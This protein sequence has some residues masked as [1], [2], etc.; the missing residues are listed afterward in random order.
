MLRTS[1]FLFLKQMQRSAAELSRCVRRDMQDLHD[2]VELPNV[3]G[4]C[5][6]LLSAESD[7]WCKRKDLSFERVRRPK[8]PSS[9]RPLPS[10]DR[11]RKR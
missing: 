6:E 4:I 10:S 1:F 7:C 8:T 2:T 3:Q 11:A 5:C 9:L